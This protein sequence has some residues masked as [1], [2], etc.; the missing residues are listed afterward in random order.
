[1]R[2]QV[3]IGAGVL[4]ILCIGWSQTS[5]RGAGKDF[6]AYG[7]GP[8]GMRY[9]GLKQINRSNVSK[10]EVAWTYD[11]ADGPGASQNQPIMVN[12]ILYGV[13]SKHKVVALDAGTG[14]QL[15]RFDS[16]ITGRGPN[17]SV[18]HWSEGGRGRIF[19]GIQSFMY[20]L[21]AKTGNPIPGFGTEGRIDLRQD[22]GRDPA[23]QSVVLTT[24]GIIYKD[25]LIMGGRTSESLPASPGDIRAYDVR[26]GRLRWT[27]HTIPRPGEYGYDTWPKDAWTYTGAANSWPGMAL[28]EKRGIVY[29]P[30]GSAAT[31]FYGA[32]RLGDNLFANSLIALN[33]A[34]GKR[35]WHFQAIKHD[36]WDRDFPSPPVLVTV[37]RNGKSVDAVAQSSKHGW[38][39]V[40][41]RTNGK[42]LF[43][44]ETKK[45]PP[46]TVPGEKAAET[47]ALPTLPAP[48]ARQI[49][50]ED[51]LSNRTPEIHA[52]A[53][54]KFRTFRS[55]GQFAPLST[56]R[57]TVIF[58]GM[59]GGA[60]W[61]GS[62]VDPETGLL[63]V[64]SNDIVWTGRLAENTAGSSDRQLYLAHCAACHGEAL[65]GAPPEIPSLVDLRGRRTAQQIGAVIRQ[66]AGRMPPFPGL[67]ER[68]RN[69]LAS[70]VLSGESK[71]LTWD[72]PS[73]INHK[74][75]FTGI[76]K[77]FA[78]D[79]YPA[80]EPPWGTLNAINLN[81]GAYAWKI[82]LGEYPE[83]AA[84]GVKT[85]GT[86]NYGGPIVTAGGLVFIGATNFD[87]KFRAFD[88][89]TGQLLWETTLPLGGNTTPITYELGGRQYV[90]IYATGGRE[91]QGGASGG[92]Y[93][94]FALPAAAA[95]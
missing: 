29:V 90:V 82:P 49:L 19:A 89:L 16:G 5:D 58:P 3:A 64:N 32:D 80:V 62:A 15:W 60:E 66:G 83:L 38:I 27:F 45:Y 33:A 75:G 70:Y 22:L 7:G 65:Q 68:A 18:V 25:L 39:Y 48:F 59:D 74:Y 8:A 47:Q 37:K 81:T 12:G 41:D 2:Q 86:E 88:K 71:D 50:T 1:M 77:F 24:P 42:P 61:G 44:M 31:D 10:L 94:A 54:E 21:D 76:Y 20:A 35:I 13:T 93:V 30:T 87:R 11:T 67:S 36:I 91:R 79:G 63:Y 72:A 69:S 28:D 73:G 51:M 34:T 23:K 85:T 92:I 53:L 52:W 56:E 6:P 4:A 57:E 95:K 14:K 17:R 9:S 55:E 43:P 26:T 40:F 46:S 84:Q 78:P